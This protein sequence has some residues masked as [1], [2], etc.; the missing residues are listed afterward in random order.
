MPPVMEFRGPFNDELLFAGI[1]AREELSRLYEYNL[2]LLSVKNDLDADKILGKAVSVKLALPDD[3]TRYFNGYVSRFAQGGSSGR[4]VRYTAVVR[5]W[6]WFLTRTTDCRIFQEM[7]V[8]DII[9]KVFADDG[10]SDFKFDLTGTYRKWNY[11]VQY[12]ET[13]YNFVARLMEEEGIYFYVTHNDTGQNTVVLTDS[14]SKHKPTKGYEKVDFV[15]PEQPV[16]PELE[17]I[18]SWDFSREIQPG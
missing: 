13:D 11:C 5:P 3:K 10:T 2:D 17:H 7:T 16:K 9:K 6:L 12:R 4:Y 1:H 8:P 18:S 15:A 14:T